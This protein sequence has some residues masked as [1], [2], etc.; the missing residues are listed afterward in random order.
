MTQVEQELA[1]AAPAKE[2]VLT[3]GVFD[4]V[5]LGHK[6]LLSEIKAQAKQ[7]NALSCVVTFRYHPDELLSPNK[8][9]PYLTS[10]NQRIKLLKAEGIDLVVTLTFNPA[11]AALEARDF[12]G[13]LKEY[14]KMCSLVVGP[15]FALGKG[16]KGNIEYLRRVG[17]EMGFSITT[18]P[19]VEVNHETVSSTA[20][21]KALADG[22]MKRVE[23]FTGH[24]FSFT[25][26]V[27]QGEKR[28]RKL[29][30]PTAN[31]DVHPRQALPP[32]GIYATLAH[33]GGK[34]Y[35]SVTNIGIRP[36]FTEGR[37]TI[38]VF[39][40][41]FEKDIYGKELRVDFITKLRDEKKFSSVDELVKQMTE[42]VKQSKNILNSLGNK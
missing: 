29:G 10:L 31:L 39:I 11:L 28:G 14:L 38:E 33:I 35:Q 26:K 25:G 37:R 16:R 12:A 8:S 2:T 22:N 34:T 1:Q 41:D 24:Y 17:Q 32:F 13:L 40:M 42:D 21:R 27:V 9:L 36:T 15:D 4:G 3:I 6:A 18:V 7:L 5:H 23:S 30:F 20:I 19:P